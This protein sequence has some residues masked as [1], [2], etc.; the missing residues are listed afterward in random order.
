[1]WGIR[2]STI[3]A[4]LSFVVG[5]NYLSA[6]FTIPTPTYASNKYFRRH[7]SAARQNC[8]ILYHAQYPA[9]FDEIIRTEEDDDIRE[10]PIFSILDSIKHSLKDKPNLLLEAAP[11]A[12]KTTIVP[13]LIQSSLES[14][15]VIAVE[16][17]RVAKRSAAFRMARLINQ[18]VGESVGY[19][20]R[21][22]S[23]QT[24]KT[25]IL[26]MT[27][28][29]LLNMILRD[30]ELNGY[31][32][33]ILD[34]FHERGIGSD[35]SLALLREVQMNYRPDLKIIVMSA[36]LLGDDGDGVD[37]EEN[38]GTK[39]RNILGGTEFCSVLRSEGRQYP[40]TMQHSKRTSPRHGELLRD[41]K[42]LVET[43]SDA[44]EEGLLKA[45][46]KG[47]ILAFLPG[48]KEIRR[49][50][51]EM[52]YRGQDVDVFPLYG[53]L[54]KAEQDRAIFK[55]DS[56]QRRRVIVSSPIA[57]ASLTIEG[58]T[59]VVD[60][61][62][63]R[64]PKYDVNTG[65]PHLITVTCSKDS[66]VQ[67][68]GRAGRTRAGYCIR[69]FSEAEFGKLSQ[70]TT[71]EI[72][73]TDLVP[74]TLLLSEWGCTSPDEIIE[75]LHFIDSPP[76]DALLKAY[77]MLVDL[78][79]L[80]EYRLANSRR[81]RYKVSAHGKDLV[82]L[83]THP[84][85][86]TSIIIASELGDAP[87]AAAVTASALIDQELVGRQESN[88]ALSIRDVLK[89]GP[90]SFNGKQLLNFASRISK[91]AKSAVLR[92]LS[93]EIA[94]EVSECVGTALLPGF[95]DLIAQRKGDAS[96]GGS[97]YMLSLGQSARLDDKQDEG[98]YII[99]VDT[100]TGDDGKTRIRA[101]SKIDS[102][103]LHEVA[104]EKEEV[105]VVASKGY[106]V[107][108]RKVS[109]AGSL[110][111]SSTTLPSPSSDEITDILLD[112]IDSL[113]GVSALMPMQSK[114]N[115]IEIAELES[116]IRFAQDSSDDAWPPCFAS[117]DAIQKRE[118]TD[119]DESILI[120]MLVP[121][122]GAVTSLKE[123]DLLSI[124]H[125]QLSSEQQNQID[126]LFPTTIKAPDGTDIPIIYSSETG[127][128][129]TAKLQQF[130]GQQES[131]TVGPSRK[132]IPVSLSLLS[133]S[134]KPLAQTIDLPFFWRET[135]P[136]IRA[137]MRGR[138]PKHPWPEDPITATA[139][140]LT[141]KQQMI[142]S[143]DDAGK[144]TDKRKALSKKVK[145]K[146]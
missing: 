1:M 142:R 26:V 119:E 21:G 82:H 5:T 88:L 87:L 62:L 41:T 121:W 143:S 84:R 67:R 117:L 46:D 12:G 8:M 89:E 81:K 4:L 74:T 38:A 80:E 65:L 40:I 70:H 57:E 114:K 49:V 107:R 76:K 83:A 125:S 137:E 17:R 133:P 75:D 71:A 73:S 64:E 100:S 85:F 92:A 55:D 111:L 19:A 2:S 61:G 110:I 102:T 59:L 130:F 134:G 14:I 22:E 36:T 96:Y 10:L 37:N 127:P 44:I 18:P 11:G 16:P 69:L 30:P 13:L 28:G 108:K 95:V 54:P 109:R 132:T 128:V 131:P 68:A 51:Q 72:C 94:K 52:K 135:Y 53:A 50:V 126:S 146:R 116:R 141:N 20:V 91:E 9:L 63:R 112:T 99:V 29:V 45:P 90:T 42:L 39:L 3:I 98:D 25:N 123:L 79:A 35:T 34:E 60:S 93:G 33:V 27:D 31:G 48:A 103:I 77:Q 15:N 124:L 129:A 97:T 43:M 7:S 120:D 145:K 47:D 105:Y 24:S 106:Q 23:R 139:S 66:A 122:L 118:G 58:V 136:S 144:N 86:A 32:A 140:R 78:G 138:Y 113:G 101:Y 56:N 115:C 104:Q 6:A